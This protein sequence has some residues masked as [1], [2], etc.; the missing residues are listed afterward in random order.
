MAQVRIFERADSGFLGP[1]PATFLN[2]PRMRLRRPLAW[3]GSGAGPD[4]GAA[5]G[6]SRL[7]RFFVSSFFRLLETGMRALYSIVLEAQRQ[8]GEAAVHL[9]DLA[10]VQ[11]DDGQPRLLELAAH[12][13]K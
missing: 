3:T 1:T 10:D 8:A 5:A 11:L 4:A 12:P 13:G 6:A 2:P 7:R 9:A